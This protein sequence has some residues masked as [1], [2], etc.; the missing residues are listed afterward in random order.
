VHRRPL[1]VPERIVVVASIVLVW[2]LAWAHPLYPP[3]EGRY[4]AAAAA[5]A[6]GGDWL[7]PTHRGAPHLT[8]PPLAY[9]L[10]AVGVEA[11]GRTELAVRW[12]SLAATSLVLVVLFW[13]AR[14]TLGTRPAVV[15][16]AVAGVMPYVLVVGRLATTDALVALS[17]FTA[18]AVGYLL[19]ERRAPTIPA[20]VAF[21]GAIGFGV[22]AKGPVGLA[23]CIILGTWLL[24]A[25]RFRDVARF[26]PWFGLPLAILPVGWWIW[27]VVHL[28]ENLGRL[29]WDETIGRVT[30]E[31]DLR[32]QPWW[33]Y[34]P[35]F[36]GGLYPATAMLVLPVFNL[37]PRD[38]LPFFTAGDL[39]ALLLI[40]VLLPLVG[41]S[42]STG[43][44][45]T[46]LLPLAPPLALLVAITIER[47]LAGQFDANGRL[48]APR[49]A[50]AP[51]F[52]APD[53]RRTLAVASIVVFLVQLGLA[54]WIAHLVPDLWPLVLPL[55]VAPLCMVVL[56]RCWNGGGATEPAAVAAVRLR[57]L[58]VAWFGL[59]AAWTITFGIETRYTTLMSSRTM[60]ARLETQ[61]GVTRPDVVL[62]GFRDPTIAFYNGGREPREIGTFAH[63]PTLGTLTLPAIVLVEEHKFERLAEHAPP[64]AQLLEP[65]GTWTK[66][67]GDRIRI[68]ILPVQPTSIEPIEAHEPVLFPKPR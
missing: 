37:R 42:L 9:W 62:V 14:R 24:L 41:F 45:A 54:L 3:D 18:L 64:A 48:V 33:F 50:G 22:L 34:L 66:W 59:A 39:R 23:P 40:A 10:Q 68:F 35:L 52:T 27:S 36:L 16:V 38:C 61:L 21:W 57:G 56:W 60:L 30:G 65:F 46:Y 47:W 7:V 17:W 26:Q 2:F 51:H 25:R 67:F 20:L 13:F 11:L 44:L 19:A 55:A 5:M 12:P 6:E 15:A 53:V 63:L 1:T 58:A 32:V 31:N 28:H 4:G 43:K 29:W 49:D 8:K